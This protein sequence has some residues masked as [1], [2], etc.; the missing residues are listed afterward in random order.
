MRHGTTDSG[1]K[2]GLN[3]S[4]DWG[5]EGVIKNCNADNKGSETEV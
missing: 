1:S 5:V 2:H 3:V 4:Q